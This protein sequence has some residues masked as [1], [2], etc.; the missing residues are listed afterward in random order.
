MIHVYITPYCWWIFAGM[1]FFTSC[2]TTSQFPISET[3]KDP[4][5]YQIVE[6]ARAALGTRYGYGA[7]NGQRY[8]CSG[9]V[10]SIY[11]RHEISLPR[12][13]AQ[14]AH[15]GKPIKKSELQPGDLIFFKN[16]NKIDHVAIVSRVSGDKTWLIHSTTSQGVVETHLEDSIYWAPRVVSYRRFIR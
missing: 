14:M 12:S 3:A 1:I 8:D 10:Y 16:R 15:S 11:S 6:D 5:R 7:S 2:T 9:L 13:T 4:V